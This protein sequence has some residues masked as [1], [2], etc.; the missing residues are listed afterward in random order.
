MDLSFTDGKT[1]DID[2]QK[3][4]RRMLDVA[5]LHSEWSKDPSTKTGAVIVRPD[6]TECSH[7]YNGFP[8]NISDD[9]KIYENREEKY[10]RIVH[11]EMNALLTAPEPVKGYT[12]YT[13]P[14]M[15][16][17]RCCVHVIQA[18]ISRCVAPAIPPHLQERWKDSLNLSTG[19]F[20]EAGVE[21][22]LYDDI[23]I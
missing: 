17:E 11:C 3:W 14:F 23:I 20:N 21:V 19:L 22:V 12:L 10:R 7:G 13:W 9:P 1:L 4:D 6:R 8:R 5:K 2:V 18:G 15:S 16:C